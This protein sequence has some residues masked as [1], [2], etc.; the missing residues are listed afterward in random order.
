MMARQFYRSSQ[1]MAHAHDGSSAYW[2]LTMDRGILTMVHLFHASLQRRARPDGGGRILTIV[3][4]SQK[5]LF[6]LVVHRLK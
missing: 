6:D 3:H 2:T 4:H 5:F 1:R